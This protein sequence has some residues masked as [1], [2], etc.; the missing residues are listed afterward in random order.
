MRGRGASPRS[1]LAQPN[2]VASRRPSRPDNARPDP[3][4]C[5]LL[6]AKGWPQG[7][8]ARLLVSLGVEEFEQRRQL[9]GHVGRNGL[10]IGQ[11]LQVVRDHGEQEKPAADRL[12]PR[13]AGE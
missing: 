7:P 2:R 6:T 1:T 10:Q 3:H 11:A 9:L 8:K 13:R 4:T 12:W 5:G